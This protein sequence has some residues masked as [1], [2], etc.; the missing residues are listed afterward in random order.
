M[1]TQNQPIPEIP[2]PLQAPKKKGKKKTVIV[3]CI[4]AAVLLAGGAAAWFFYTAQQNAENERTAYDILENNYD[5]ADYEAFLE[6]YPHSEHAHEVTERLA[7]LK[8]MAAAWAVIELSGSKTDFVSFKNRYHDN[9]YDRMCDMKIDSLDWVEAGRIGTES[10][11]QLYLRLHPDGR[12]ASDAAIAAG[13]IRGSKPDEAE[14]EN[15]TETLG[16]FFAGFGE[17]NEEAYCPYIAPLMTQFLH[18]QNATKADVVEI[19]SGMFNEHILN[20]TFILNGDFDITKVQTMEGDDTYRVTFSVDQRIE[21]DN[22][23]KTFGSYTATA[24]LNAQY[25]ITV[26]T[27]KEISRK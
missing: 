20:C 21:R 27:M 5:M 9:R 6:Q 8:S 22:E 13:T 16:S 26:L 12:Y 2:A 7:R 19:I 1:E 25:R 15:I 11:Y 17:N 4:I 23:G 14:R 10:A 24:E 3:C 18:K